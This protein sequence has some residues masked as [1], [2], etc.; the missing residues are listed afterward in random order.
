M[1]KRLLFICT[2]NLLRSPTAEDL[3]NRS[4]EFSD[5]TARSA[6]TSM[7]AE[8]QLSKELVNW[9]DIIFVF[10]ERYDKHKTILLKKFPNIKKRIIDLAIQD[11]YSKNDPGLIKILKNKLKKYLR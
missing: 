5:Y 2:E 10:S 8:H 1:K 6:G 4:K 7:A 9:A 11:K 3:V